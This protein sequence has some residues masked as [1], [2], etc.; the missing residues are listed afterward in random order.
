MSVAE[1]RTGRGRNPITCFVTSDELRRY[2]GDDISRLRSRLHAGILYI[3]HR[4]GPLAQ[5]REQRICNSKVAGWSPAWSPNLTRDDCLIAAVPFFVPSLSSPPLVPPLVPLGGACMPT[6]CRETAPPHTIWLN[7][8]ISHEMIRAAGLY[9][10]PYVGIPA[11]SHST[12]N[13]HSHITS[14]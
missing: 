4:Y 8:S 6:A 12:E 5:S 13:Q 14:R 11:Y 3:Y 7:P 1:R 9:H 10:T 2:Y